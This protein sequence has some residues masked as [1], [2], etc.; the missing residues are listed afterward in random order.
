MNKE[1]T[2]KKLKEMQ[3]NN[4][5]EE[6]HIIADKSLL[7]FLEYLGYRDVTEEFEKVQRWYA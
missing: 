2:I 7:S 5:S 1:E 4:D 6:A 3:E